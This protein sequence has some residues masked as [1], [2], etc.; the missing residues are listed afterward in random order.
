MFN[1]LIVSTY[2]ANSGCTMH[3]VV[4]EFPNQLAA[5]IAY[6]QIGESEK[7]VHPVNMKVIKLY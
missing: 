5:D 1:L 7:I 4:A 6:N 2:W 3:Q